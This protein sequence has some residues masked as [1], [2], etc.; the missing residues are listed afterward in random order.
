MS[1]PPPLQSQT[2]WPRQRVKEVKES[3]EKVEERPKGERRKNMEEPKIPV[4]EIGNL[5]WLAIGMVGMTWY[6]T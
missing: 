3:Q 5:V 1:L 2:L 6:S 4:M